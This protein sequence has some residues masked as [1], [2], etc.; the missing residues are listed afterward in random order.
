MKEI[1]Q[2]AY[3]AEKLEASR[4]IGKFENGPNNI[5]ETRVLESATK[6][7]NQCDE[8]KEIIINRYIDFLSKNM[9]CVDIDYEKSEIP[10][11]D[12]AYSCLDGGSCE[13]EPVEKILDFLGFINRGI[14]LS[15]PI[16]DRMGMAELMRKIRNKIV[17]GDFEKLNEL[18]ECY[19]Q[20][21]MDERFWF[22]Y[23]E[24]THP[25]WVLL[26]ISCKLEEVLVSLIKLMLVDN[27][28]VRELRNMKS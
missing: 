5:F 9:I 16:S 28:K 22:D 15:I 17:H 7:L 3:Q 1:L 13:D 26:H 18:L 27:A 8:D 20:K 6:I 19:A 2:I 23:F 11:G 12:N 14:D 21:Y 4:Y 10:Y 25:S 24:Y